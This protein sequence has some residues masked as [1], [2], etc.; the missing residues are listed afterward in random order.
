[1]RLH[2]VVGILAVHL[3]VTTAYQTC[4]VMQY[5]AHGDGQVE[6]TAAIVAAMAACS[7]GGKV[8]L[9]KPHTFLSMPFNI[10]SNIVFSVEGRCSAVLAEAVLTTY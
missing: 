4:N 8:L 7:S 3:V 2:S 5:G 1:M 9:P 10:T 6:D